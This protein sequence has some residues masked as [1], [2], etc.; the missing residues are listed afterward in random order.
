LAVASWPSASSV[1]L[2]CPNWLAPIC[3]NDGLL[4]S[5]MARANVSS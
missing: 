4:R 3:G 1:A 2:S 5:N